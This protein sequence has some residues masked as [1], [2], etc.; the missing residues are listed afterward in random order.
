MVEYGNIYVRR[1]CWFDDY[2]NEETIF[3]GNVGK[4]E[5]RKVQRELCQLA[6][7][8]PARGDIR[9]RSF[10]QLRHHKFI[11]TSLYMP[12]DIWPNNSMILK[13]INTRFPMRLRVE[14]EV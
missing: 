6:D 9:G 5:A 8:C 12:E 3:M 1:D 10:V 2:E 11:V 4:E 14:S 13:K 7:W